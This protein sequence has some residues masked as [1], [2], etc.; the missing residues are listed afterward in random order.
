[1]RLGGAVTAMDHAS[2]QDG[3]IA[4]HAGNCT[5]PDHRDCG[6]KAALCAWACAGIVAVPPQLVV[7]SATCV[8]RTTWVMPG[9]RGSAGLI[10]PP[11]DR[12]PNSASL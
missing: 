6:Q 1:M 12:P 8:P 11:T 9:N 5:C 10:P 3:T 2:M 7:S 4:Y